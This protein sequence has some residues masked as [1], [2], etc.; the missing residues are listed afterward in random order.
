MFMKL[1]KF[2][3]KAPVALGVLVGVFIVNSACYAG[4]AVILMPVDDKDVP[5]GSQIP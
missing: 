3:P 4:G 1:C 2:I 5:E